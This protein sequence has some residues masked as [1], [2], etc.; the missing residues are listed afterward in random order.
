MQYRRIG[1]SL[2]AA[3]VAEVFN[4]LIPFLLL[5]LAMRRLG[6]EGFG[7]SQ[8]LLWLIDLS[9]MAVILGYHQYGAI[10]LGRSLADPARTGR[11]LT[12]LL[13]IKVLNAL[14]MASGLFIWTIFR[15]DSGLEPI[16]WFAVAVALFFSTID[17]YFGQVAQARLASFSLANIAAKIT[18]LILVTVFVH[19]PEDA[20]LFALCVIASNALVSSVSVWVVLRNVRLARPS[21]AEWWSH[22]RAGLAYAPGFVL[23]IAVER[24]DLYF[25]ERWCDASAIGYYAAALRVVQAALPLV[26]MVGNIFLAEMVQ[27]TDREKLESHLNAGLQILLGLIG[28]VAGICVVDPYLV[29]RLIY[30]TA[31]PEMAGLLQVLS[32]NL[33]FHAIFYGFGVQLLP[34]L[35]RV[36]RVNQGLAAAAVMA[37]GLCL[38]RGPNLTTDFVAAVSVGARAF[39]AGWVLIYGMRWLQAS[40]LRVVALA[41]TPTLI[42]GLLASPLENELA[43]MATFALVIAVMSLWI[44]RKRLRWLL[45]RARR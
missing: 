33:V 40:V 11:T 28:P 13:S 8:Y 45:A 43:K 32:L 16:A 38:V 1:T 12:A 2:A 39:V 34:L 14:L 9:T 22:V 20:G 44:Q 6:V 42:A 36:R 15:S 24:F 4:K 27:L 29:L 35:Q 26:F 3:A 19:Q 41:L 17:M 30:G 5:S 25:V 21:A 37:I 7:R 23:L 18:G 10:A 31:T